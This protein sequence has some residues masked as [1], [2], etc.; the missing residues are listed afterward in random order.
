LHTSNPLLL[1]WLRSPIIYRQDDTLA[2]RLRALAEQ[3]LSP[4]RECCH[5][6]SMAKNNC[7]ERLLVDVVRC[8][9]YL[10]CSGHCWP[11]AGSAKAAARRRA[12]RNWRRHARPCRADRWNQPI[13]RSEDAGRRSGDEPA[14]GGIHAFIT[15]E[16]ERAPIHSP[17][18]GA[19]QRVSELDAFLRTR[20]PNTPGRVTGHARVKVRLLAVR[21]SSVQPLWVETRKPRF[22]PRTCL[23]IAL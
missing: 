8:K 18:V 6:V 23:V 2:P 22:P 11:R 9:K 3:H 1:E 16:L 7:R 21:A 14:L 12:L 10:S 4:D 17:A 20:R 13:A 15:S 19:R 5:Y